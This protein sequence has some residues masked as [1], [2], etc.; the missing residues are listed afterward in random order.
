M[1]DPSG[2]LSGQLL[3]WTHGWPMVY[4]KDTMQ[5]GVDFKPSWTDL[6]GLLGKEDS[7]IELGIFCCNRLGL[8]THLCPLSLYKERHGAPPYTSNNHTINPT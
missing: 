3:H 8:E 1:E 6:V 4:L 7:I 5:G 2:S